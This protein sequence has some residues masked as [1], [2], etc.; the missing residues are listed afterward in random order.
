MTV[1]LCSSGKFGAMRF[2]G[3][4]EQFWSNAFLTSS[5]TQVVRLV[6]WLGD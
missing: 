1:E 5:K 3:A 6:G 2:S 4:L